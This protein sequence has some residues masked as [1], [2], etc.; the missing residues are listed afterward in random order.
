METH[1]RSSDRRSKAV[2]VYSSDLTKKVFKEIKI[3]G[4]PLSVPVRFDARLCTSS[5]ESLVS[6]SEA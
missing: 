5:R 6:L 2:W 1:I 3:S 4:I